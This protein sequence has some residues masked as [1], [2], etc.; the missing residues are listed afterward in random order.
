[1]KKDCA[2]K[3]EEK[4]NANM[5]K[6][7]M[8][9]ALALGAASMMLTG[10]D[11]AATAED[12]M[13]KY[14][15]ANQTL[16]DFSADV[17]MQLAV[18]IGINMQGVNMNM[19]LSLL[20]NLA[21]DFIKDPLSAKIGGSM[22][23]TLPGE[24]AENIDMQIYLVPAEDGGMDCYA[25]TDADG[26]AEWEYEA[27]P[28][29]QME[30][31]TALLANPQQFSASGLPGTIALADEAVDV[32]GVSCYEL[33]NTVTWADLEPLVTEAL[34]SSGQ[35]EDLE[36]MQTL[37]SQAGMYLEGIQINMMLDIDAETY[38][39]MK[40]SMNLDGSD[41]SML[42]QILAYS[43]AQTDDDGNAVFPEV[44]LDLS[45]LY[46]EI[47]YDYTAPAPITVPEEGLAAKAEDDG[48]SL[49]DLAEQ[50]LENVENT[51]E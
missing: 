29:E 13:E 28:A 31:I 30:Q 16:P 27:V 42:N 6:K 32:N 14:M 7:V 38:R 35:T 40:V 19:D 39:V 49:S 1:M 48:N 45:N 11:S 36:D 12:V 24:N 9:T 50:A 46:M 10:F 34:E 8:F 5:K 4:E 20:S 51:A 23:L 41:L 17:D 25:Y 15:E 37:L 18:G 33:T 47:V 3:K 26:E 2:N 44:S 22:S 21:M 43:M